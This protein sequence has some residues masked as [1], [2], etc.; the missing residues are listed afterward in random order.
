MEWAVNRSFLKPWW[1]GWRVEMQTFMYRGKGIYPL[2]YYSPIKKNTVFTCLDEQSNASREILQRV[3]AHS[4][5]R[6]GVYGSSPWAIR[7]LMNELHTGYKNEMSHLGN[8][9]STDIPGTSAPPNASS[10][11]FIRW[12]RGRGL[13]PLLYLRVADPNNRLRRITYPP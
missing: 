7:C 5:I 12:C 4:W 1:W 6:Q 2:K 3:K 8:I 10:D 9:I 13:W 11:M